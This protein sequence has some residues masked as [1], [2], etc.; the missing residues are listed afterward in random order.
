MATILDTTE[1]EH[2]YHYRKFYQAV[3]FYSLNNLK[4]ADLNN[5][6]LDFFNPEFF[7]TLDMLKWI[8][9]RGI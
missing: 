3:L 6:R 7:W 1:T 2:F 9:R 8:S 5:I 4:N